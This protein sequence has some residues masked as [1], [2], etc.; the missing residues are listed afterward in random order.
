MSATE[1]H[2]VAAWTHCIAFAAVAEHD[3]CAFASV[4]GLFPERS[5]RYEVPMLMHCFD[6]VFCTVKSVPVS[7]QVLEME[8]VEPDIF[9]YASVF[10]YPAFRQYCCASANATAG[11]EADAPTK[12]IAMEATKATAAVASDDEWV[13]LCPRWAAPCWCGTASVKCAGTINNCVRLLCCGVTVFL[14]VSHR[15]EKLGVKKRGSV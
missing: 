10:V 13:A 3:D 9:K 15:R 6:V 11:L 8:T 7:P 14:N 12:A 1:R 4:F 5:R 2:P